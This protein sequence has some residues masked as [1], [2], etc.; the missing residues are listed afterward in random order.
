[1]Q[2]EEVER[3]DLRDERLRRRH[4]DLGAGVRVHDRVG[5]A[6]DRGALRVADRDRA[7]AH[8][9]RVLHGHE[10]VHGL[11][12]LADGH[13]ERVVVEHGLAVA[14]LVAELHLDR[15]A[16]PLLDGVLGHHAGV[17]GR[18][19]R[20]DGDATDAAELL[21]AERRELG[22]LH[23]PLAHATA[24]G[25]RDRLGLLGHL[26]AHERRPAALLGGG[27]VPRD[28]ER[29]DLDGVAGE[30]GDGDAVG[31]DRD[32]LVLADRHG[33]LRV[34][35]ERGDIRAQEVLAL[36]EADD[37]RRVAAGADHDAGLVAV[38]GEQGEGAVEARH[39]GAECLGEL[40]DAAVLAA[41]QH[42]GDLGV[43]LALEGV[44]LGEELV[45]Q[46]GEVLDDAVVDEGESSVVAEVRVRVAVGRAAVRRPARVADAGAAAVQRASPRGRRRA[47]AAC[48]PASP[49]R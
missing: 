25:V 10:R 3:G 2:P 34:L 11:A 14:E 9:T 46:L 18:A 27:R 49:S 22:D 13:D 43:G 41:E 4:G 24:Q 48:R 21:V 7:R 37:Q 28:V 38:H 44:A 33:A 19:A 42:G 15:H 20:D 6:R 23:P 36:A 30:V 40:A 26:L 35:D 39:G 16:G 8:L 5:L 29:L 32:D 17:G 47:P 31:G 45:L 1:M 12:R